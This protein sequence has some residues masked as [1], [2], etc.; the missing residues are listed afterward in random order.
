ME[1]ATA[2]ELCPEVGATVSRVTLNVV[3]ASPSPVLMSMTTLVLELERTILVWRG[4]AQ[5]MAAKRRVVAVK[6]FILGSQVLD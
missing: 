1:A 5:A 4:A 2:V 3:A 6:V